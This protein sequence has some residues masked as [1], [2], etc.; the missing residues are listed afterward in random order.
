[1]NGMRYAA[2]TLLLCS[3][4]LAACGGVSNPTEDEGPASYGSDGDLEVTT[5]PPPDATAGGGA[6][7]T[8]LPTLAPRP[9][10]GSAPQTTRKPAA[11]PTTEAPPAPTS[12]PATVPTDRALGKGHVGTFARHLL[13]P[14]PATEIVLELLVQDGVQLSERAR[15]H[16][17]RVL[18]DASGKAV[19]TPLVRLPAGGDG[20]YSA[21]EVIRLADER[22]VAVQGGNQAVIRM[23]VLDGRTDDASTLGFA[24][25]GDVCAIFPD[26][27]RRA[28]SPVVPY[29]V[30]EDAVTIHELGH[31][32]GLVDLARKTGREDK[33][34]PS[35]SPNRDSVMFWAVESSLVGQVLGG[36]PPTEF[37]AADLADLAA[38]RNGA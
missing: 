6:A 12:P 1:M 22:G 9:G 4:S 24:V 20:L 33:E 37:D 30:L 34:H 14:A 28:E 29:A 31:I 23:L 8:T 26:Q 2:V 18:R 17:I 16:A 21:E 32:L 36:G 7:T 35:H 15:T 13:R 5:T 10:S 25:R 19:S 27:V 11:A 38:L 3:L